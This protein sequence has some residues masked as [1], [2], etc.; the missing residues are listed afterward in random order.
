MQRLYFNDR[1]NQFFAATASLPPDF[2]KSS[3]AQSLLTVTREIMSCAAQVGN[4]A[5][6]AYA[7]ANVYSSAL[8]K[9][10]K[11]LERGGSVLTRDGY[12]EGASDLLKGRRLPELKKVASILFALVKS[13]FKE[14]EVVHEQLKHVFAEGRTANQ[15]WRELETSLHLKEARFGSESK[16]R[17][18][19][20]EAEL[21]A[22]E[23]EFD[24]KVEELRQVSE[25]L[26]E[27]KQ[28]HTKTKR[29]LRFTGDD[30]K[31][32]TNKL[33]NLEAKC[34]NMSSQAEHLKRT[35]EEAADKVKTAENRLAELVSN[36]DE[37]V[38]KH[39][40]T[41]TELTSTKGALQVEVAKH[42]ETKTEL[43][44]TKGALQVAL[45]EKKVLSSKVEELEAKLRKKEEEFEDQSAKML[46]MQANSVRFRAGTSSESWCSGRA[47]PDIAALGNSTLESLVSATEEVAHEDSATTDKTLTEPFPPMLEEE[48]DE[49]P[50]IPSPPLPPSPPTEAPNKPSDKALVAAEGTSSAGQDEDLREFFR[51]VCGRDLEMCV[52]LDV[53]ATRTPELVPALEAAEEAAAATP[54]VFERVKRHQRS[55]AEL[56]WSS[57]FIPVRK[58]P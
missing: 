31:E 41:K 49:S 15:K 34:K 33:I 40:E 25:E 2:A 4:D 14:K 12:I 54:E 11:D 55:C 51:V 52:A 36:L 43:T 58:C 39:T 18:D 46:T 37:E 27:E 57:K 3:T 10:K 19:K 32:K 9:F 24:S 50:S 23:E 47:T 30:C 38:A 13:A 1:C 42:T 20:V 17:L 45:D 44:S 35:A 5:E 29:D 21:K 22:C 26:R 56:F 6:V 28:E 53:L 8:E 48:E 16:A 7:N